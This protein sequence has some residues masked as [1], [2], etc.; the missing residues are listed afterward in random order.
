MAEVLFRG[1]GF[2]VFL[3]I[4][5]PDG[6]PHSGWASAPDAA[7]Y[8]SADAE[9]RGSQMRAH[10]DRMIRWSVTPP[11]DTHCAVLDEHAGP[12]LAPRFAVGMR[13]ASAAHA[14][15]TRDLGARHGEDVWTHTPSESARWS[16]HLRFLVE[17]SEQ[18][19]RRSEPCI[20]WDPYGED[21]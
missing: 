2:Y 13:V 21:A 18:A 6:V 9:R 11:D 19:R 4:E 17:R 12:L 15:C 14:E 7:A 8:W 20:G 1:D 5:V 10:Y 16:A 3:A